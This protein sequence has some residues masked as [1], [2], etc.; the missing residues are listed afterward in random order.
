MEKKILTAMLSFA[1]LFLVT[2]SVSAQSTLS[3]NF[4]EHGATTKADQA[5][6][7]NLPNF[8]AA[9]EARFLLKT[10]IKVNTSAFQANEG[11]SS[12]PGL[13]LE[14]NLYEDA[15]RL[16]YRQQLSVEDAIVGAYSNL[17]N[18]QVSPPDVSGV[19]VQYAN[20]TMFQNLVN[21][22]AL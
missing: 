21:L 15:Y 19:Q 17:L 22:L 20:S 5:Y 9:E 12:A 1:F 3:T 11:S 6:L 14:I 4:N 18:S 7:N 16:I 8:V 10:Q 13:Q 2:V